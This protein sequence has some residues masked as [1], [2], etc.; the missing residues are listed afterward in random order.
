MTVPVVLITG[1]VGVGKTT[2]GAAITVFRL[3]AA[4]ETL[5]ARVGG[6]EVGSS[7]A[8]HL[9]RS[10][11]LAEQMD[12]DTVEDHLVETTGRRV[13]DIAREVLQRAGWL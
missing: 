11:E 1:P 9:Y 3:S 10:I 12:R 2:P 4:N 6:R 7:R 13:G 8:W 5:T